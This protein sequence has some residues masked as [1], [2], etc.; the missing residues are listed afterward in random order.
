MKTILFLLCALLSFF[1]PLAEA[2]LNLNGDLAG[3]FTG[4]ASDGSGSYSGNITGN[5]NAAGPFDNSSAPIATLTASGSF[6]GLG[7]AGSWQVTAFDPVAKSIAIS[8]AGPGMRGP[9]GNQGDGSATLA[10]DLNTA[11]ASGAFHGQVYTDNGIKTL[12][13]TWTIRFQP[14]ANT[15]LSG[16]VQGSFSGNASF[17]GA[18]SGSATGTWA[19]RLLADGT[20]VGEGNGTYNGGNINVSGY[21]VVCI[22]GT[23]AANLVKDANG[24]YQLAGAW[25]H[26]D[27]SGTLGGVGGGAMTWKLDLST[28]PLQ[29]SGNFSGSTAFTVSVPLLGTIT[30]PIAASGNWSAT[31]PLVN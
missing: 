14:A 10:L 17:V 16:N 15:K 23:W 6:G 20:I 26:P 3:S 21:G 24:Q 12:N 13:G 27:V 22:C 1:A 8:W 25:T 19:A 18:V 9:G 28:V 7:V 29:A 2:N 31:L 4:S 5:W 11:T 30:V